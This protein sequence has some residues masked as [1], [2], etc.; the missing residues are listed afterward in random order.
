MTAGAGTAG[1]G[2]WPTR[3]ALGLLLAASLGLNAWGL[4]WGLPNV[5][6][7]APDEI[8]PAQ[9]LEGLEQRFSGGWWNPYPPLHF[10]LMS[11]VYAPTLASQ[12]GHVEVSAAS[13]AYERLFVAGRALSALMGAGIVLL[14]YLC[15]AELGDPLAGLGA[16]LVSA[17]GVTFVYYSKLANFD[18]PYC[19]WSCLALL[20]F[21]R[22]LRAPTLGSALGYSAASM[23]AI[24]TKDQAYAL[25]VLPWLAVVVRLGLARRQEAAGSPAGV[26]A[27]RRLLLPVAASAALFAL[28]HNLA[29]NLDGFVAHVRNITGPLGEGLQMVPP[30]LAGQAGLLLLSGRLLAFALGVP[31]ALLVLPGLGLAL[32]SPRQHWRWLAILLL[33]VSYHLFFTSVVRYAYDRF[34]LPAAL[35]LALFAGLALARPWRAAGAYRALAGL[36]AAAVAG[37]GLLRAVSLCL[38]ID[39][40]PR[41]AAEDWLRS[42]LAPDARV[43]LLGPLEYLPRPQG[44][45]W[46]QR[47]E[48]VRAIEGMAPDYVIINADYARRV[49]DARARELY[50]GLASGKLGYEPAFS[51][52]SEIP[53]PFRLDEWLRERAESIPTNLDKLN[54]E[55]RVYRRA[56]AGAR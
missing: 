6:T 56:A 5:H 7:W 54:P 23:A 43:A 52:R 2:R 16:G 46:K 41:Y 18:V 20:W 44:A 14:L 42:N 26:V 53:W 4:R 21:L 38:L 27:D 12:A 17:V 40:D 47:A 30:G 25:F 51:R 31:A 9:V 22:L 3:L 49:E 55:I 28:V 13:A 19:F 8:I 32:A 36:A 33:P 11:L 50:E 1:P 39:A 37:L 15:G 34:L 29:F 10:Y 45:H 35:V 24:L 48:L